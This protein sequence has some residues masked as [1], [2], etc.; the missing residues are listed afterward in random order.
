MNLKPDKKGV[1]TID[2]KRLGSNQHLHIVAIDPSSTT[3]RTISLPESKIDY[4]D[5]R[6]LTGLDP[7]QHYTQQK[8]IS[9]V[10]AKG[11]FELSDITTA[12]FEAYDRL[13]RVY[14]DK[15]T[16]DAFTI[17]FYFW[18]SPPDYWKYKAFCDKLNFNIFRKF[19]AQG[20]Q[21]TLPVRHS[22]WKH[23]D[24]QGPLDV[25]LLTDP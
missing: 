3:Y 21:F 20:I 22:F 13:P 6:L 16:G 17:Q 10:P 12:R 25:K 8:Q 9:V 4:E 7:K 24:V 23:D 15:I 18:N 2:R 14:F 5:L 11:K 19:D 1:V